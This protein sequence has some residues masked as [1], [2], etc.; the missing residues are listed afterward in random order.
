MIIGLGVRNPFG[1]NAARA[2]AAVVHVTG[3]GRAAIGVHGTSEV[4][5]LQLM[6]R[7]YASYVTRIGDRPQLHF[8]YVVAK[9]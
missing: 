1:S 7:T 5:L 6:L 9:H 8:W 4:L 2:T 3:A